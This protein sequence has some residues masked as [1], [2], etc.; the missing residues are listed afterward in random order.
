L[1]IIANDKYLIDAA[2]ALVVE[3]ESL[4]ER[5][6]KHLVRSHTRQQRH[7]MK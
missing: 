3:I 5:L 1:L 7:S 2:R 6:Q 4:L